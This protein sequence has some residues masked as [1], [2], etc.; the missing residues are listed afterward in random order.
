VP[1]PALARICWSPD[2]TAVYESFLG[3]VERYGLRSI[4]T[5]TGEVIQVA[6]YPERLAPG[7]WLLIFSDGIPEAADERGEE[8]GDEGLLDAFERCRDYTAA[9]VC[10]GVL[11][12]V[13]NHTRG[14]RQA[15]D[16]TLIALHV[17]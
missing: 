6:A 16:L 13:R 7:D 1:G 14:Q 8:F 2:S 11:H 12:E 4:S 10:Q 17:L 3:P 5:A 9:M 15:D